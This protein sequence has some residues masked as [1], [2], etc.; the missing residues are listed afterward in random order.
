MYDTTYYFQKNLQGDVI[1][2]TNANGEVVAR[3]RYDAWGVPTITMDNTAI[4][5]AT[6]NPFRYRGY[7]Y[8]QET[9]LYYLQSRYYDPS[10]GRF[11]NADDVVMLT[12]I[13][14]IVLGLNL[15]SYVFNDPVN[16]KDSTGFIAH[17]IIGAITGALISALS[18]FVE[19]WLGMRNLNWWAFAGIVATA[20]ALGAIG[21][22]ISGWAKFAKLAKHARLPK[23]FKKL[24]SPIVRNIV[25]WAVR[26][27]KF[28]INSFVKKLSRKPGE[29]WVKAIRRWLNI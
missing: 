29:S 22:Y 7:Y 13:N 9:G 1:A 20:A 12:I 26:G 19:Y 2:I 23:L 28:V 15:S 8:D 3:Y 14:D 21:G 16:Q 11:V 27:I 24:K 6:V 4:N 5:I 17:A 18:Y 10:V 25:T